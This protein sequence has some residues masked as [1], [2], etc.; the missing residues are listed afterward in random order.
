MKPP[1]SRGSAASPPLPRDSLRHGRPTLLDFDIRFWRFLDEAR[2]LA[3][4]AAEVGRRA[5][6]AALLEC[7]RT[8]AQVSQDLP[9]RS[10]KGRS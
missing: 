7:E 5:E 3:Q 2:D 8:L 9:R 10:R 4:M 1:R 6:A